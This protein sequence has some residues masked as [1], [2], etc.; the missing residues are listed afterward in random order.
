MLSLELRGTPCAALST[1][2]LTLSR[3]SSAKWHADSNQMTMTRPPLQAPAATN[4][5]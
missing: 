2:T 5:L 1:L 4:R 3:L